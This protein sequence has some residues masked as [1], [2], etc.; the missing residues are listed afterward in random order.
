MPGSPHA[1]QP[2]RYFDLI[3]VNDMMM[4][5]VALFLFPF[6][7]LG[8][9][10]TGATA[11]RESRYTDISGKDCLGGAEGMFSC[12]GI[13]GWRIGISDEGNIIQ[14][15]VAKGKADAKALELTGRGLGEKAEWRGTQLRKGFRADALIVRMRPVEDDDKQSS[16]LYIVKLNPAG[17]C[18]S[19]LVD[20]KAN[21]DAN[22]L[23]RVAADKLPDICDPAPQVY[24]Q[25]SAA[26]DMFGT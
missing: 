2:D 12:T 21:R 24:G 25:R 9:S 4:K 23:A 16:L 1:D 18:L 5:N 22:A 19:G 3:G 11:K 13:G 15:R 6:T 14:V 8:V 10:A 7:F 26:T 20:A 17:P